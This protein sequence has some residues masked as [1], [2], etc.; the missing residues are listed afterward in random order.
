MNL[1]LIPQPVKIWSQFFHPALMW[2]LLALT[3]YA[4][5]LGIKSKRTRQ[6]EG[7]AKKELIKGK[8]S[9]R[10]HQIGAIVLALMVTGTVGGM[11]V[12]YINNQKLFVG[13]HLLVGLGMTA[14]I[15]TSAAMTPFMQKGATWAR[16]IHVGLNM[17]LVTLFGWQ[18]ITGLDIVQRIIS[19]L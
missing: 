12:T 7:E 9:L 19:K 3:L 6:A 8:Y 4:L 10:H 13:P 1:D 17:S 5:Y 15:A 2:V 16:L 14:M 18:A 11:A